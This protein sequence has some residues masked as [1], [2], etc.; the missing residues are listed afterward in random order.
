MRYMNKPCMVAMAASLAPGPGAK[1]AESV[2][3]TQ[4][5]ALYR[6]DVPLMVLAFRDNHQAAVTL[7]AGEVLE[8]V[9]PAQD[10]DR[11]VVVDA[12]GEQ[13]LIFECDLMYRGKSLPDRK[14]RAAAG[15]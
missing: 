1:E 10:D 14:A 2:K 3:R 8:V 11:F 4:V 5:G 6:A 7:P 9:G 15:R 12:R 13:F